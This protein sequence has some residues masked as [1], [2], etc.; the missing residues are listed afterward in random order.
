[1]ILASFMCLCGTMTFSYLVFSIKII[2]LNSKTVM[3]LV[4]LKEEC[5]ERITQ[6]EKITKRKMNSGLISDY[7]NFVLFSYNNDFR[8]F[9]NH[10]FYSCLR[11]DTAH[12]LNLNLFKRLKKKFS[13][14][15]KGF[16]PRLSH[17]LILKLQSKV[18][19]KGETVVQCGHSSPGI[20]F[21]YSGKVIVRMVRNPQ[22][23][24]SD[25]GA[26]RKSISHSIINASS[27]RA[28]S[29]SLKNQSVKPRIKSTTTL[30]SQKEIPQVPLSETILELKEGSFFGEDFL[31]GKK[32]LFDYVASPSE[33]SSVLKVLFLP[34]PVMM[35][36]LE[37]EFHEE[38]NKWLMS[39]VFRRRLLFLVVFPLSSGQA[40]MFICNLRAVQK[41]SH[42]NGEVS[43]EYGEGLHQAKQGESPKTR[44]NE[45]FDHRQT[46]SAGHQAGLQA[47][48]KG[49]RDLQK[50]FKTH[51]DLR[52]EPHGQRLLLKLELKQ[53]E[54]PE[55]T[56]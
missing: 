14:F 43:V 28:Q 40:M 37:S 24:Q 23:K 30:K 15:F 22:P 25:K 10:Y 33:S 54:T 11:K 46:E 2:Y 16:A 5:E 39:L 27:F 42:P 49:E 53:I 31:L 1:M 18:Y 32:P 3:P 19:L 50:H 51:S 35:F 38:S 26:S 47:K 8:V 6:F 7:K 4:R 52:G 34:F 12:E 21:I 17:L 36:L 41:E 13:L 45:S 55:K 44:R 48:Q 56:E 20:Y 9:H 29:L